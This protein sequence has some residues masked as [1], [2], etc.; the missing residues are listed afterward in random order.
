MTLFD[1]DQG[2][3]GP[4][5]S[6]HGVVVRGHIYAGAE[7]SPCG[8]YRYRLWRRETIG[9]AFALWCMLNPSTADERKL[10]PTLRRADGFSR[11]LAYR[12]WEVVNLFAFRSPSPKVLRAQA[13][14]IGPL[15]DVVIEAA[16]ERCARLGGIVIVGWGYLKTFEEDEREKKLLRSITRRVDA[17]ALHETSDGYPGHPLYLPGDRRPFVFEKFRGH[18]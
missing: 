16:V 8:A 7:F 1:M 2:V 5:P 12:N 13:D 11:A 9:G 4:R 6:I 18:Q 17:L 14:P 3:A 10:D 15:N